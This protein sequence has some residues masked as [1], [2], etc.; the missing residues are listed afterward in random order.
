MKYKRSFYYW[1]GFIS[2]GSANV[3]LDD[4]LLHQIYD[5]L[6][7]LIQGSDHGGAD[8]YSES[9]LTTAMKDKT[10]EVYHGCKHQ[11]YTF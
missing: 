6:T 1:A 2:H 11:E 5:R 10:R 3:K 8:D 7:S 4:A 9:A